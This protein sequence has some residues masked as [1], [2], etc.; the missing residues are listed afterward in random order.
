MK[1]RFE[2]WISDHTKKIV[3]FFSEEVSLGKEAFILEH[4]IEVFRI[5]ND[6]PRRQ[7]RDRDEERL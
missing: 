6:N 4:K 5:M 3:H 1:L 2:L 7:G